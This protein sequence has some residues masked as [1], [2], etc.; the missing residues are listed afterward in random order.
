[1][2][3]FNSTDFFLPL[4]VKVISYS[5][6]LFGI[7]VFSD[8]V[9]TAPLYLVVT[10]LVTEAGTSEFGITD[11]VSTQLPSCLKLEEMALPLSLN[12]ASYSLA[13]SFPHF[14]FVTLGNL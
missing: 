4:K 8:L 9:I 3:G 12:S 5:T 11:S 7:S 1:P 6:L 10:A 13:F 14:T 2:S